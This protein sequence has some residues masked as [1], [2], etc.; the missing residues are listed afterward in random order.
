MAFYDTGIPELK[1]IVTELVMMLPLKSKFLIQLAKSKIIAKPLINSL[2]LT[3]CGFTLRTLKTLEII[4]QT[5][6]FDEVNYFLDDVKEDLLN[7]LYKILIDAKATDLKN[8][9]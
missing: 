5:L 3:D 8:N 7:K 1:E 6:S 2:L 9:A 4:I